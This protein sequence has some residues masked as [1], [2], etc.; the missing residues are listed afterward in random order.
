MARTA[1]QKK[2]HFS[3]ILQMTILIGIH[4]VKL[5]SDSAVT[6]TNTL[7]NF[8][9]MS[10]MTLGANITIKTPYAFLYG[11]NVEIAGRL[12]LPSRHYERYDKAICVTGYLGNNGEASI[13]RYNDN[14]SAAKSAIGTACRLVR[15]KQTVTVQC[16][17]LLQ[18]LFRYCFGKDT[19]ITGG[20]IDMTNTTDRDVSGY[21]NSTAT[22]DLDN[23]IW[24]STGLLNTSGVTTIKLDNYSTLSI[25]TTST[26]AVNTLVSVTGNSL[27]ATK[28]TLTNAGEISLASSSLTAKAVTNTGTIN[29]DSSVLTATSLAN[30]SGTV[31]VAG[32]GT[33]D[34]AASGGKINFGTADAS[35]NTTFDVTKLGA[36]SLAVQN[37]EV[38]FTGAMAS[39]VRIQPLDIGRTDLNYASG[40]LNIGSS[41]DKTV[42]VN[43]HQVYIGEN[44]SV[45]EHTLNV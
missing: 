14:G 37:G 28:T 23:T 45:N 27:F 43:A 4:N 19:M 3:A 11:S 39:G 35:V 22:I 32:S 5:T 17:Q 29:L 12:I 30:T 20:Q 9:Q 8:V 16:M 44:T 38:T 10:N 18:L 24:K 13:I 1:K 26:L 6:V 36:V 15:L 41:S 42:S 31:N 7:D 25:A 34:A 33:L 2:F 21:E 40:T